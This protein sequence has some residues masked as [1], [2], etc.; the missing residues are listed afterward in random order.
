MRSIATY[1]AV[2]ALVTPF[3]I[4]GAGLAS[5]DTGPAYGGADNSAT[6]HGGTWSKTK[7]GFTDAG[8]AYFV[9]V[10]KTIPSTTSHT[11]SV[12]TSHS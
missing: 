8:E 10:S 12:T 11:T 3:V 6:V 5:A 2:G 4:G 7:S 1:L 9:K